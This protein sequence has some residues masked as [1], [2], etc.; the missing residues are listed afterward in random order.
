M[1]ATCLPGG[2][3]HDLPEDVAIALAENETAKTAWL[4]ITVLAR[5]EFIC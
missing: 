4:D 5:N 2:K 3:V 1:A